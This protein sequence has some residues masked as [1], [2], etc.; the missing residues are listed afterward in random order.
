LD[1]KSIE[2]EISKLKEKHL[3]LK[4]RINVNIELMFDKTDKWHQELIRKKE[5]LAENKAH[6]EDTIK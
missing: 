6:L 2:D 4:K 5:T 1:P 3:D